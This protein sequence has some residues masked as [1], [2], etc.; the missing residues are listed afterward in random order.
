MDVRT[1]SFSKCQIP[2]NFPFPFDF[3]GVPPVPD[4]SFDSTFL[5]L[6]LRKK[7]PYNFQ[8]CFF[9]RF[10]SLLCSEHTFSDDW[11]FICT[12][13]LLPGSRI[14]F[15]VFLPETFFRKETFPTPLPFSLS[16]PYIRGFRSWLHLCTTLF[17]GGCVL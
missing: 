6:L 5:L 13:L 15:F 16:F 2:A 14:F 12:V 17:D 3:P 8:L 7:L 10:F 11:W 1:A 4:G 9:W